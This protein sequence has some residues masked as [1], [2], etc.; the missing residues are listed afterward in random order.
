MER[1]LDRYFAAV[2]P[3]FVT[4]VVLCGAGSLIMSV[5]NGVKTKPAPKLF[6]DTILYTVLGACCGGAVVVTA[7]VTV[8]PILVYIIYKG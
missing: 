4:A 5:C 8:S 7:P 6:L 3:S 2:G 1:A